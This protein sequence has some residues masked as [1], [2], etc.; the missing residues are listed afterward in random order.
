MFLPF[1]YGFDVSFTINW[2]IHNEIEDHLKKVKDKLID[3]PSDISNIVKAVFDLSSTLSNSNMCESSYIQRKVDEYIILSTSNSKEIIKKKNMVMDDIEMF[4]RKIEFVTRDPEIDDYLK[5]FMRIIKSG[6]KIWEDIYKGIFSLKSSQNAR[7]RYFQS[8]ESLF[9]LIPICGIT[10]RKGIWCETPII[11][12]LQIKIDKNS[13]NALKTL[14]NKQYEETVEYAVVD[15][16]C[17]Y[18]DKLK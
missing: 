6:Y 11:D 9:K 12:S 10:L 18:K 16:L 15:F 2:E 4:K 7:S 5:T 13:K 1:I 14:N 3:A 17:Q 8:P